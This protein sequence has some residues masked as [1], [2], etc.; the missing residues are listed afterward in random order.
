MFTQVIRCISFIDLV[1]QEIILD[2]KSDNVLAA[3]SDPI[4][5]Q[6]DKYI[7]DHPTATYDNLKPSC[8][9]IKSQPLTNFNLDLRHLRVRLI[10]YGEGER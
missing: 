6:I 3:L 10:D 9:I 5:P 1:D 8:Q 2:I 4:V 7:E